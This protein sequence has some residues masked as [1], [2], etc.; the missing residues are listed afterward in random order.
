MK[1]VLAFCIFLFSC[2]LQT[3]AQS[4]TLQGRVTDDK[5]NPIELASVSCLAQGKATMTSLKGE[6]QLTLQ[7]ADSVVVRFS[8]I[9]Y[10]S[11]TRVL[12]HPKGRQ[13]LQVVLYD[14][15]ITL[16]DVQVK[17]ERIQSGQTQEL[18]TKD[19][20][21]TANASGNAVEGMVQSQAGVSTH[22]ELSSQYNV[23]GGSFNENSVYINNIEVYRPFLVRSG[24][25][26]GLSIIN[27]DM[28]ERIGFST[29]GFEA[30]YG[31]KMSS[32]LDITYKRPEKFEASLSASML[33]ASAYAA[34]ANKKVSWLNGIRYKTTKYLLGSLEEK[35]EYAPNFLD[36]QTYL[37]YRP[38]R[39]WEI[40]F[41]GNISDSHYNFFPTN[42]NTNFGTMEN[43]KNFTVYF[44]G[45][46][47]DLFRT[48]FGSLG[49]TYHLSDKTSLKLLASAYHT[50][51]QE[52]YDIQGQ[53]WL[54]QTETSENLGV[55]TYFEHAR[56]YLEATVMSGKVMLN[57]RTRRH[58]IEAAL[59]LKRERIKENSVEY[60][61]RDS[62]GYSV[63]HTG[64]DLYMIYS[65]K[66]RN[67]LNAT[68]MEAYLQDTWRFSSGSDS[69]QTHYT[70]N[71]GLRMSHWNFNGETIVSPRLSLGI[72]PAFNDHLMFRFATGLY[73]QAPFF[74][75]LRDTATVEHI[76]A[77]TLNRS[78]KSQRSLHFIAGLDYRFRMMNRP[79]RFSAEAYY[80]IL[81]NLVPYSVNN[82]K[83]VYYGDNA[84]SGHAMGLDLKLYGEFV[85][86]TDS[87]ITLSLMD[88]KM[89]LN[90][91]SLPLPTDQKWAVNLFFTDYFPG[92]TR[93]KMNLKLAF[94]DGL[95]FSAPH[96]ELERNS[97]RAPAYKRADIG[98]SYR[99]VNNEDRHSRIALKNLWLGVDCL[100]LFGINNV[101]SYYWITDVTSQQ[102]AVP[103]YLTGRQ[104]NA[105]ILL[106]F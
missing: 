15:N 43:V 5:N 36:Y 72:I 68:R 49:L 51:E 4:F 91:R 62:A 64:K 71:Y 89:N 25:Q 1:K 78:I 57:H 32:A 82:V 40:D 60:E 81:Q 18:K 10:R 33:G 2:I 41:I 7:S 67:E 52:R 102:Y 22:S 45:Q 38:N 26:E 77:A 55:G 97:F 76:T 90:G 87:W 58:A 74:K 37:N 92:T 54:T 50:K 6:F 42:R 47:K 106:E 27:P 103:N 17:G 96:R 69:A 66:A 21:M 105:R 53:Y 94:A 59:T 100:N 30:R 11:K 13:T 8:M 79:F 14:D 16:S 104:I 80:K 95:P 31:D 83:V 19:M 101:N 85:P 63:P 86:G 35:G 46:E 73:Y 61:M 93:W 28:V 12:R 23:R 65:M 88:T 3:A 99:L 20:K 9:G 24:Q 34:L 39:Y 98:M 48:F 84:C 70:L 44:D 56:N 75:E 29:G